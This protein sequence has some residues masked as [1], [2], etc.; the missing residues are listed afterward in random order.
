MGNARQVP[1]SR[2]QTPCADLERGAQGMHSGAR[3]APDGYE[4]S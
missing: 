4:K 2:G 1:E 3:G